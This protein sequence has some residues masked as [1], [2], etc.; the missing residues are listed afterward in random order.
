[1]TCAGSDGLQIQ[2]EPGS[3]RPGPNPRCR[4]ETGEEIWFGAAPRRQQGLS[5]APGAH[6]SAR[7]SR[8]F[9]L[10]GPAGPLQAWTLQ[11]G[12]DHL[13]GGS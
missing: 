9:R 1:M 5:Q 11:L 8:Q 2:A 10:S 3:A 6:W 4:D 12:G 13:P 7:L